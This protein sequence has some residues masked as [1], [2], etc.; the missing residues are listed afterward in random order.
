MQRWRRSSDVPTIVVCAKCDVA[1]AQREVSAAEGV[2]FAAEIRAPAF[3][4]TSAKRGANVALAFHEAVRAVRHRLPPKRLLTSDEAIRLQRVQHHQLYANPKSPLTWARRYKWS[5]EE[6]KL[7][8]EGASRVERLKALT[9]P[10][11]AMFDPRPAMTVLPGSVYDDL[12]RIFDDRQ[13]V[14]MDIVIVVAGDRRIYAHRVV[15]V[16]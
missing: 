10:P 16:L 15:S 11:P 13:S 8:A 4:E 1:D 5:Q 2:Q 3:V 9:P 6:R 14:G 12:E 7:L